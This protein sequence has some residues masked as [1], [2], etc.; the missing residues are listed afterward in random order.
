MEKLR[1]TVESDLAETL[2]G[3]FALPVV[4]VDPQGATYSGLRGRID[5]DT[6]VVD[7]KTGADV[8]TH[9]PVVTLR[10]SSL[11]RVPVD[12]ERWKVSIPTSPSETATKETFL[13]ER[14]SEDGRTIGF[15]RL[16]LVRARQASS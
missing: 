10:V 5:Y 16:F 1:E 7:P 11:T 12:G 2:E 8:I 15:I 14:A 13:L 6:V 4:L 9:N 3:E